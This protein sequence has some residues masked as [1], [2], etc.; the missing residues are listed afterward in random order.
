VSLRRI[1]SIDC[2]THSYA[3]D[4]C[5]RI[6]DAIEVAQ[7]DDDVLCLA[8]RTVAELF[9]PAFDT[10]ERSGRL[11]RIDANEETKS[12][13]QAGDVIESLLKLGLRK[14]TRLLVVGGGTVQDVGG[15]AASI[16]MRGLPWSLI[17][18][19]L[20][21]QCDSCVGSKSSINVGKYK[22]QVGTFWAPSRVF[23]P[24]DA[25]E[26]LSWDA[27]RSGIGEAIKLHL[28]AGETS[29]TWMRER[30]GKVEPGSTGLLDEIVASSIAIK[31][32]YIEQDEFDRGIRNILN[33]GHTF[34][35]AFESVTEHAIPHGIAVTL[36]MLAATTVS[37]EYGWSDEASLASLGETFRPWFVPYEDRLASIAVSDV[38]DAMKRDKKAAKSGLVCILTRGPGAMEMVRLPAVDE[39]QAGLGRFKRQFIAP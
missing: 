5:D 37:V 31:K 33:Y 15:Y 38:I 14:T 29:W 39:V 27:I 13:H 36:G 21:G 19:T 28:L 24:R 1:T 16:L 18:T 12:Y 17:S 26:T 8:D 9:A 20:L 4:A 6:A 25:L 2:T 30:L 32:P 11:L 23:L 7:A 10:L 35:H 22:N 3:V 34:G